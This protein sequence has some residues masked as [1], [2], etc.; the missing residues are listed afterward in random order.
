[1]ST[2]KTNKIQTLDGFTYHIPVQVVT[3]SLGADL[4]TTTND[5]TNNNPAWAFTSTTT[6][7]TD[8]SN[9]QLTITPKFA[10]SIIK[11]DLSAYLYSGGANRAGALRI[12]RGT[13]IVMRPH[14]SLT[15]PFSMGYNEAGGDH[16]HHFLTS[17]D[18]P[19]TTSPITY[20]LQYRT[21]NGGSVH[22]FA[23]A[24]NS[25]FGSLNVLTATE[26]AQ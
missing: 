12:R 16:M 15:G 17:Y 5:Q 14:H 22:F 3:S 19:A 9:L 18:R 13:T 1:M 6:T 21:F 25:N 7:W 24:V 26:I 8:T 2:I 11:L 10:S 23:Q 4:G 20:T